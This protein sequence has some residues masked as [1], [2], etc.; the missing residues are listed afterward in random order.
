MKFYKYLIN[1]CVAEWRPAYVNY[2]ALKQ[3]I[4]SM[5]VK[6][7]N[8]FISNLQQ[9][10]QKV[11][12]FFLEQCATLPGRFSF[13]ER[14]L[15]E[16]MNN[17]TQLKI[18]EIKQTRFLLREYHRYCSFLQNFKKLNKIAFV[19]IIKKYDKAF[20]TDLKDQIQHIFTDDLIFF[21]NRP[22]KY[23]EKAEQ[24]LES[25]FQFCKSRYPQ[26]IKATVNSSRMTKNASARSLA[27]R[28]LRGKG[29][30]NDD[31]AFFRVGCLVGV[32]I[33]LISMSIL[34]II[35]LNLGHDAIWTQ[36]LYMFG[37]MFIIVLS[38]F[39][40][41]FDLYIWRRYRI[42]YIFIFELNVRDTLT[43]KQ[44]TEFAALSLFLWSTCFYLTIH[45]TLETSISFQF[46][47]L[48]LIGL[49]LFILFLP[50]PILYSSS[51][52]W[53][54]KTL[55]YIFTPGFRKVTFREFFIADL[56]ISLTFFWTSLYLTA[57]FYVSG[58][59]GTSLCRPSSSWMTPLLISIP[60][61]IR[62]I[63]CLRKYYDKKRAKNLWNAL[64][65]SIAISAVF[66]S[67]FNSIMKGGVTLGI[68]IFFAALSTGYSYYWDLE[69][70]WNIRGNDKI[71]S[72]KI[73]YI[74]SILNL[75]L[76]M[77]WILTINAFLLFDQIF[78]S[79]AFGCLEVIRRYMWA[80]FRM[81]LEHTH[82]V[83]NF[84]AIKDIPLL[85]EE[86]DEDNV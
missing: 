17:S 72:K 73:I 55:F 47:P 2:K 25:L 27:M 49:Y 45:D 37:G 22:D 85:E 30:I 32:S 24:L 31:F 79:F 12:I 7:D 34:E 54:L 67:S 64:K 33:P 15:N 43:Y 59:N 86:D 21:D 23:M 78:L 26:V 80:I 6:D 18:P 65:Y 83:E 82:N 38:F 44:F 61:I 69:K 74:V 81:E 16:E 66:A 40:F 60:F 77:N 11:Q 51:R 41:S 68:W 19:K 56:L 48:L 5:P 39:G 1:T 9:E 42:N 36:V 50:L 70:D 28:Y 8:L 76:R 58:K 20:D 35:K 14:R 84:R 52:R 13:L 3:L 53:F 10:L 29:S 57:C 63:Q 46:I 75:I 71:I 4:K 62:L